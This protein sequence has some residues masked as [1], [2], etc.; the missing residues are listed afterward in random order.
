MIRQIFTMSWFMVLAVT[1]SGQLMNQTD[2]SIFNSTWIIPVDKAKLLKNVNV[3]F[4]MQYANNN[5]FQNGKYVGSNFAMNQ[6]RLEIIGKITEKVSFR[7]RDRYT[8]DFTPQSVDNIDHSVD[9]A[10]IVVDVSPRLS[11]AFGKMSAVY[12]GFEFVVNPIYIYQYNEIIA[13]ADNYLAGIQASWKVAKNHLLSFQILNS[14]TRTFNEIYDSIPGVTAAK[15]PIALVWN[16]RGSFAD[17]KFT[18]LWSY[19]ILQDARHELIYYLALGNQFQTKKW[20]IQY[21]FKYNPED[22]DRTTVITGIVPKTYSNYAALN[23][24]YFE[25][26]L[27][28][29]Y[30]LTPQW[31]VTITGMTNYAYWYGNPDPNKNSHLNSSYGIIPSAEFYPFKELNLKF[32]A[33]YVCR[34]YNYTDYSKFKF[35]SQNTTTGTLMLGFITPL[36]VL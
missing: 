33:A 29:E 3:I 25:N 30:N 7:F 21:D 27:H 13:H 2:S 10:F 11:L 36:V 1:S 23:T 12:G 14:R 18:T 20:L 5:Y 16:W 28:I 26:W 17:G 15:F 24:L 9:D 31:K 32:F 6:F 22:I 34:F 8:R 35:G 19:A 4:N